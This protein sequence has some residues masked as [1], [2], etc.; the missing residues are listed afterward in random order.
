[1]IS[2]CRS[3]SPLNHSDT[4]S[5]TGETSGS[6]LSSPT[7][8]IRVPD[9]AT[10]S[11]IPDE[12]MQSEREVDD[13]EEQPGDEDEA[14]PPPPAAHPVARRVRVLPKPVAPTRA[15]R[16]EHEVTHLKYEP[17]CEHCVKG[18]GLNDPHRTLKKHINDDATPVISMDFAFS[19]REAQ[20]GTSPILVV[21][22][23]PTRVT[24]AH[25]LPGKSTVHEPYSQ[26]TVDAVIKDMKMVDRKKCF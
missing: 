10:P 17:W 9:V 2:S 5:P 20:E 21:R 16:E 23:H 6:A 14:V 26:Y 11:P 8:I 22:D 25:A 15:Q 4:S 19:K 24:F 12:E 1:M 7:P 13:N 18:K 3:I